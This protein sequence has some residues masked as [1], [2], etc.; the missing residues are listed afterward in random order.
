[1]TG[2]RLGCFAEVA[3]K[4]ESTDETFDRSRRVAGIGRGGGN[5]PPYADG[6]NIPQNRAVRASEAPDQ[7]PPRREGGRRATRPEALPNLLC[8]PR[9]EQK[10]WREGGQVSTITDTC[11]TC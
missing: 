1:M 9:G 8:R 3:P 4:G 10:G 6:Q 11:I 7:D 5:R 2:F